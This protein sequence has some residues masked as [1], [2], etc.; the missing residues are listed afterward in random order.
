MGECMFP[1]YVFPSFHLQRQYLLEAPSL[2][3]LAFI[4]LPKLSCPPL[5]LSLAKRHGVP[6]VC[7]FPFDSY[8]SSPPTL[9]PGV[10]RESTL[11]VRKG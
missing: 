2:S 9:A 5:N 3:K 10:G 4:V 8:E 11:T 1:P 6:A 7:F